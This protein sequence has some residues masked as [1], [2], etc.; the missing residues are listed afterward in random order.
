MPNRFKWGGL[1]IAT[2]A[3]LL[4]G[5]AASTFLY[6][7]GILRVPLTT[8][9]QRMDRELNLTPAQ[10][11]Q[12]VGVMRDTHSKMH[13]MRAQ[14]HQQRLQ[15]LQQAYDQIRSALTPEQQGKFDRDFPPPWLR[16]HHPPHSAE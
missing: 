16:R 9:V 7:Y 12:I 5:F 4:V 11:A 3:G 6:R 14:F 2:I 8:V 1:V 10:R 13:Q 15:L